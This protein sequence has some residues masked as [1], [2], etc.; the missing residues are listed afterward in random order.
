MQHRGLA[1]RRPLPGG[2]VGEVLVVAQRLAVG[3]LA[4]GPE[5]PTAALVA[6]QRVNEESLEKNARLLESVLEDFGVR[7]EIVKIRPGP[8]VTLYE[9]EPAAGVKSSRVIRPPFAA[10]SFSISAAVSP[11]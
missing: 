5:V 4:L 3:G 7:G 8:V 11:S 9:F 2:H 10:I 6:V 1:L